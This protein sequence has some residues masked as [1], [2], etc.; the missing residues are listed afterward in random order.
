[1]IAGKRALKNYH[2][3]LIIRLIHHVSDMFIS[4]FLSFQID[5]V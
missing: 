2:S 3:N 5:E 1:L 4:G